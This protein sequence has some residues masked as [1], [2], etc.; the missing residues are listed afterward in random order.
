MKKR[1]KILLFIT[2]F[3]TILLIILKVFFS[4]NLNQIDL[5]FSNAIFSMRNDTL[6]LI[7]KFIT[8]YASTLLMFVATI[9]DIG[10]SNNFVFAVGFGSNALLVRFLKNIFKRP[11]P[12]NQL[13]KEYSY[14]FP[15]GHSAA[16]LFYY[17]YI[18]YKV[19]D[20]DMSKR[21]KRFIITFLVLLILLIGFSRI[22]LG[23]HY[24]SDVLFGYSISLTTLNIF[25]YIR[26]KYFS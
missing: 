17:G 21:K 12:T 15:S 11:R 7:M 18:I 26:N 16:A 3:I 13:I 20:S 1:N 8:I 4:E 23:V 22:Y 25:L 24:L 9:L 6:S 19:Y 10:S 14:S 2:S 5:N